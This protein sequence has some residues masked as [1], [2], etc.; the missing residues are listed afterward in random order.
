MTAGAPRPLTSGG[1][2]HAE[3]SASRVR[4]S[5]QI[6]PRL[7][8]QARATV[9]GV[10]Q[11]T[12]ADYSLAQLTEDAIT[13]HVRHLEQLYNDGRPFPTTGPPLRRGR[14]TR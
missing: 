6:D 13:R 2:D 9:R 1:V 12:G 11:A 10:S 14:R 5:T 3:P 4:Y 8:E 7:L